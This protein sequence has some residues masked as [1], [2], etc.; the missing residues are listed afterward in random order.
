MQFAAEGGRKFLGYNSGFTEET[1]LVASW[2]RDRVIG[3][4]DE[5]VV[6]LNPL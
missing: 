2:R 3:G 4:H 5:S 1:D 6:G